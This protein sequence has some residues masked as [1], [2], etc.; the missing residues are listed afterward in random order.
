MCILIHHPINT[1]FAVEQLQDFYN[2]NSD[3]F[4]AIVKHG[5]TVE[6]IKSIGKIDEIIELYNDQ[7]S[8]KEAII[9][10]R[11][12]THGDINLDNCHPY[13]V[14][15]GLYMAHNGILGTGNTKD[16]RMSDTWHYINEFLR[17]ILLAEPEMIFNAGFQAMISSH[18]GTNNKFGF[19]DSSGRTVIINKTSGVVHKGVWYSNTYAWT[20]WKFG[21]GQPPLATTHSYTPANRYAKAH[22]DSFWD[23]RY[24]SSSTWKEWDKYDRES[25]VEPQ[26]KAK[27]LSKKAKSA[28]AKQIKH[29][30]TAQLKRIIRQS[31]N[32]INLEGHPSVVS[33]VK[34]YPMA[35]M[36]L[37]YEVYGNERSRYSNAEAISNLV[38]DKPSDAADWIC[39]IWEAMEED[40]CKIAD[41]QTN[42]QLA[43]QE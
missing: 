36:R 23:S 34:K 16:P 20:P 27:P 29:V 6:V 8:G 19:M 24:A 18:I 26:V 38:N 11:M 17:P 35:A 12:K 7:V 2:R 37:I 25:K 41:I 39:D 32:A 28:Q 15:P 40:L 3:G 43:T 14:I 5:D 4:G 9:H 22:Q 31:Y 1:Q 13:E 10:L 42:F 30:D 21:L 33:W